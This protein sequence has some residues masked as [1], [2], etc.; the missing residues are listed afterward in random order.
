M[1]T[2]VN[3]VANVASDEIVVPEATIQRLNA[4]RKEMLK[5]THERGQKDGLEWA[6][7]A[8][9]RDVVAVSKLLGEYATVDDPDDVWQAAGYDNA[10]TF[11]ED[12]CGDDWENVVDVDYAWSFVEGVKRFW[13]AAIQQG[14]KE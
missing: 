9:R 10:Y 5:K 8:H 14:A 2:Q 1:S 12:A 13:S 3:E 4:E 7:T 6:S 11:W